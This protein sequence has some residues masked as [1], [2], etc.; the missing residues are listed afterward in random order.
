M[1]ES[2]LFFV[3]VS[4]IDMGAQIILRSAPGDR[5]HLGRKYPLRG[6]VMSSPDIRP[7][8]PSPTPRFPLKAG[9]IHNVNQDRSGYEQ[10]YYPA[11]GSSCP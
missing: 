5:D 11:A 1:F 4:F 8:W 6:I 3:D 10:I 9:V 7:A 2:R